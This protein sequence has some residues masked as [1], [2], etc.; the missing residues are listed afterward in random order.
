MVRKR[1][2][3][4]ESLKAYGLW[5]TVVREMSAERVMQY[6]A[7]IFYP[8]G[9]PVRVLNFRVFMFMCC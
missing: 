9:R 6:A 5:I 2:G 7:S 4:F 3:N 1:V 8:P